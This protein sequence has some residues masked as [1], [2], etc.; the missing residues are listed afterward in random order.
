M[1][2]NTVGEILKAQNDKEELGRIVENNSG[3]VWSIVKR[4]T[5]RGY[6]L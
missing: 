3:L 1:Y 6:D 5:G 4:F 2:E